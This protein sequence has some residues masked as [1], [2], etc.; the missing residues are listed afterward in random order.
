MGF[1]LLNVLKKSATEATEERWQC[2]VLIDRWKSGR[3]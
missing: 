2:E 3:I 1:R